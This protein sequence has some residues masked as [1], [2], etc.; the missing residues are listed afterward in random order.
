MRFKDKEAFSERRKTLERIAK[1][2][3]LK[4]LLNPRE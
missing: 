2:P 3:A 4:K 1:N